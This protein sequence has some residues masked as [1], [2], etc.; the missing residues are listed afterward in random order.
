VARLRIPAPRPTSLARWWAD[1]RQGRRWWPGR[2]V[3]VVAA[4]DPGAF[5]FDALWDGW[6]NC[7]ACGRPAVDHPPARSCHRRAA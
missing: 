2:R 7:G 4:P 1:A 5:D 3:D 6:A